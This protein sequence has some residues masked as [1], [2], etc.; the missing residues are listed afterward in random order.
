MLHNPRTNSSNKN[1]ENRT[2]RSTN[3][4]LIPVPKHHAIKYSDLEVQFHVF[5]TSAPDECVQIHAPAALLAVP[6]E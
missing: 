4:I 5:L 3:T 2:W 1:L 6:T